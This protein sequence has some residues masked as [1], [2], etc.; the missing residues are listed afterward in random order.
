MINKK[1]ITKLFQVSIGQYSLVNIGSWT[2][3]DSI[4][5]SKII[6]A[7]NFFVG[8][9]ALVAV[10]LLIVAG[11]NFITSMGDADKVASAQK[12]ATAAIVGMIIVFIARVLVEL[13][14]NVVVSNSLG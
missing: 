14:I 5:D 13:I 3:V 2:S 12:G 7:L 8:F 1:D 4:V 10:I 6:T 9:S 11:Y